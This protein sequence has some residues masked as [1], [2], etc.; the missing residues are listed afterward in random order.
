MQPREQFVLPLGEPRASERIIRPPTIQNQ[1]LDTSSSLIVQLL[2]LVPFRVPHFRNHIVPTLPKSC[3]MLQSLSLVFSLLKVHH[4]R[5]LAG[6][7]KRKRCSSKRAKKKR[8]STDILR[9]TAGPRQIILLETC[10]FSHVQSP[11]SPESL[12]VCSAPK[13]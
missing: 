11:F 12:P 8:K 3:T 13:P 5:V 6:G 4:E 7:S 2:V 1:N 9:M 10:T